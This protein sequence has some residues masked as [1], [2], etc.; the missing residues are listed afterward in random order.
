MPTITDAASETML[1]LD[2]TN[3]F[4]TLVTKLALVLPELYAYRRIGLQSC[5]WLQDA[6]EVASCYRS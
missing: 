6:T 3:P 1:R 4:L 2:M 5:R